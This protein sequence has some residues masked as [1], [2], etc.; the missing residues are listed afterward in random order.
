VRWSGPGGQ[1][2]EESKVTTPTDDEK[3]IGPDG[4]A[5]EA[6]YLSRTL[7]RVGTKPHHLLHFQFYVATKE[8]GE[9]V[10]VPV[11]IKV[12]ADEIPDEIEDYVQ[13]LAVRVQRF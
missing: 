8:P 4:M 1:Q 12:Q 7:P 13:D 3:L 10:V 9:V 6:K 5:Y 2:I 11:R